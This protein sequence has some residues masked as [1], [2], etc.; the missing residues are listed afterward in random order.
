MNRK[1]IME[2]KISLEKQ[3]KKLSP[4]ST[5]FRYYKETLLGL[6]DMQYQ[7]AIGLIL[8]DASIQ[9]AK[10][11]KSALLKFEWGN[12]NKDYAF[13]VYELFKDYCLTLPRKQERINING[14]LITTW[15]FQTLSH[16][17]FLG[18]ANLFL[19]KESNK[20]TVPSGL[21]ANHLTEVG[22]AYWFMDDGGINGSHSYGL[23]IHTQS[24][25]VEEVDTIC[26]ELQEKFSFS[27]WRGTNKSMP[28]IVISSKNYPHFVELTSP[29]ILQ[30][31]CYKL[32]LR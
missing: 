8:G 24:F 6:N 1:T 9:K 13:H 32:R 10:N 28:I 2:M 20:K 30:S 3:G 26:L 14:N 7:A 22:L 18:L 29:Y 25:T 31:M 27:C 12:S 21:I 4:N 11:G 23:V 15:C 19:C 17:D 16:K 5:I